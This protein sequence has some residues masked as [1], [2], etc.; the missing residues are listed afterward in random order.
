MLLES[1]R[2]ARGPRY[3]TVAYLGEMDEAGRLG[4]QHVAQSHPGYQA[5]FFQDS[6]PEWVEV[7]VTSVRTERA[8]RFGDVW[9]GLELLKMLNL[10]QFFQDALNGRQAKIPWAEVVSV[11]AVA[12]FCE[13]QSEFHWVRCSLA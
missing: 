2:T 13:L 5:S 9:L 11:L 1:Y 7:D 3:R 4:L 12:R 8:R 6:A 10:D